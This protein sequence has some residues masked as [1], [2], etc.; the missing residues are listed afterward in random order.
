MPL[1]PELTIKV[2]PSEFQK[3]MPEFVIDEETGG[4]IIKVRHPKVFSNISHEGRK[5]YHD[6]IANFMIEI[7][8]QIIYI[9]DL[10]N[11]LQR[12]MKDEYGMER[13]IDFADTDL[14]Q[15][16]L[17]GNSPKIQIFDWKSKIEKKQYLLLREQIWNNELNNL[18][19][20]TE[21]HKPIKFGEGEPPADL[22]GIDGLKH[23]D[24]RIISLINFT[25]WDMAKWKGVFYLQIPNTFPMLGLGFTNIQAEIG[26]AS[27]RERV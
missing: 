3:G 16:N 5:K 6:W 7:M 27:C 22:F 1:K 26:R 9:S 17:L 15:S 25:L 14:I 20:E 8:C 23:K 10:E 13:G 21:D 18:P 2:Y 4:E 12:I 19:K 24:Q 11:F